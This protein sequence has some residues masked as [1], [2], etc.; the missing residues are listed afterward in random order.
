[1]SLEAQDSPTIRTTCGILILLFIVISVQAS[2][3]GWKCAFSL[4]ST[5]AHR[6]TDQPTN[7][8]TRPVIEVRLRTKQ[9]RIH[10][11]QLR[12]GGQGRKCAFSHFS[13]R[14]PLRTD[15]PTDQPTDQ[16]TN[17]RRDKA[18]YRVACP[19]LKMKIRWPL[20]LLQGLWKYKGN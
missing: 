18:S 12:T 17:R 13:T 14:S 20:N 10:G 9:G 8:W 16:P 7:G 1:M 2:G 19:Q 6:R 5:R 3:Q 15:R 4:F 11:H